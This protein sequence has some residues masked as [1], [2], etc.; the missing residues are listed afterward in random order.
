M[1]IHTTITKR[2][3]DHSPLRLT[4]SNYQNLLTKIKQLGAGK[5]EVLNLNLAGCMSLQSPNYH[6]YDTTTILHLCITIH[7]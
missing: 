1:N 7:S 3:Y 6:T 5:C 2:C 4:L